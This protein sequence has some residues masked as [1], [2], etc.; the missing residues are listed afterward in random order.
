MSSRRIRVKHTTTPRRGGWYA[1][2]PVWALCAVLLLMV[3]FGAVWDYLASRPQKSDIPLVALGDGR[4]LHLDPGNLKPGQLHLFEA[5]ASGRKVKFLV[6]RTKEKAVHV[7]L[8]S[9]RACYR[10]HD[11]HYAKNGEMICG[12]CKEPMVFES[13]SRT[14]GANKCDLA[15]VPHTE[16]NRDVVV[17]TRD[18][19]AQAAILLP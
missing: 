3:A 15:E 2:W 8:A 9:C 7:A 16:T 1:L 13:K 11:L 12:K 4:D 10:S 18:I 5:S 6:E 17:L 14:A 19:L